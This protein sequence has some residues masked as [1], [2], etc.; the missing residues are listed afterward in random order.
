MRMIPSAELFAP[1]SK[2][3][4]AVAASDLKSVVQEAHDLVLGCRGLLALIDA[5]LDAHGRM[6]KALRLEDAAWV[7]GQTALLRGFS[8]GPTEL[9]PRRLEL[10]QG[11]PRTPAYVVLMA[12]LLRGY[13]GAGFKSC[14]VTTLMQESVTLQVIL[15][16]LGLK[17][18]GR[19]T[20]TELVNAVTNATRLRI[21][22]AQIARVAGLGWD[23][24]S[25]MMQDSTHVEGNTKWPTDSRLI[26]TL[27]AR[28][29]RI[30]AALPRLALAALAAPKAHGHLAAMAKLDREIDLMP[31]TKERPRQRRK[32]YGKLLWR[33]QRV[34]VELHDAI[35][36]VEASFMTL[37]VLP[38]RKAMAG[39]AVVRLRSD[40][41]A[42]AQ[43]IVNCE[44]RVVREEKV[45][46]S[47]KQFSASDP[48]VGFIAKGQ[49]VPVVGYKPQVARSGNGFLTGLLLAQGNAADSGQLVPMLDE[50]IARTG[51]VPKVLTIDDGYSSKENFK[52]VKARKVEVISMSGAK[53]RALT[54]PDDWESDAYAQARNGRSAVESIIFTLKQGFDFDHVARRGLDAAY[55]ELLEK[56][57]AYNL[58]HMVR[59]RRA[60]EEAA[61]AAKPHEHP[62]L[63]R[64]A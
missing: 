13:C 42:L 3:F 5:D 44:A 12:M 8:A 22:D 30:G 28:M 58:C 17:M 14:D 48:D 64:A 27:T 41:D 24:F 53:G 34:R 61:A 43:V 18:P 39:R 33:A 10:T 40:L 2:L 62:P 49:R 52:A 51:V 35:T 60:L 21:L 56:A 47:D 16:N 20:L 57:L 54:P 23:D 19:S 7:A 9:D 55:A 46:A 32:R 4:L 6:K 1:V 38:S 31:A 59:T 45:P 15:Q 26:V 29:L 25:T 11:R 37:D 63:K 50:V 36:K